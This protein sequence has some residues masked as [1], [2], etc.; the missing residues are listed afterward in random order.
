MWCIKFAIW[1]GGEGMRRRRR[2]RKTRL[3]TRGREV[4]EIIKTEGG[5]IKE[6][7][8]DGRREDEAWAI[9]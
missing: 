4:I 1:G 9:Y 6:G 2:R 3:R 8:G 5:G 7:G